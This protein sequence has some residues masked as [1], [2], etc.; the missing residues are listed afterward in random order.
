MGKAPAGPC[1]E[2]A[3]GASS[4]TAAGAKALV[5]RV[6]PRGR[7]GQAVAQLPLA[8]VLA[9]PASTDSNSDAASDLGKHATDTHG[10]TLVNRPVDLVGKQLSP[11]IR[12]LGKIALYRMGTG[13]QY[14]ERFPKAGPLPAKQA[15][16]DL[17]AA[18]WDD[19]LRLAGAL[20]YGHADRLPDRGQAI[21]VLPAERARR[22]AQ[23][24]RGDQENHLPGDALVG[25]GLSARDRPAVEQGRVPPRPAPPAP[26]RS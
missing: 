18:H 12:D 10:I 24:V 15:N 16:L 4:G 13:S 22:G 6:R 19:L 17:V 2:M 9:A 26:L 5:V 1:G 11:R 20:K 7:A 14:E 3:S 25:R 21:G 8:I 23:G